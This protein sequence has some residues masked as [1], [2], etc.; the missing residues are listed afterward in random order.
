MGIRADMDELLPDM[1]DVMGE[2]AVYTPLS[3][4]PVNCKVFVDHDVQNEPRG[5]DAVT[6]QRWT[7]IEALLKDVVT[8]PSRGSSFS[9]E[10]TNYVV[11]KILSNDGFTVVM[12]VK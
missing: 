2:D 7:Q 1:F 6:W 10:E 3:G 8:E 12:A 4:S 5:F 9:V 11:E